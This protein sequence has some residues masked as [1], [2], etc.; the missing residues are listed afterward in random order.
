MVCRQLR[1]PVSVMIGAMTLTSWARQAILTRS[2]WRIR[3]IIRQ[4]TISA[5]SKVYT[6][7]RRPGAST[8]WGIFASASLEWNQTFHSS[9]ESM[10][11][12]LERFLARTNS[13]VAV[14][15]SMKAS[16]SRLPAR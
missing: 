1:P 16:M 13:Q 3:L 8:Q 9:K 14:T 11:F 12:F 6:S 5:S 10:I 4:P 15:A 7:S 2:L